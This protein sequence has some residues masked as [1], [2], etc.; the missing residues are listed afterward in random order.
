MNARRTFWGRFRPFQLS[1]IVIIVFVAGFA[2]G[3]FHNIS[4]AEGDTAPPPAA[5]DKSFEPFWQ[6][7][8][9][10]QSSYL[11]PVDQNKLVDGA[12]KGM[13]DSLGDQFSAYMDPALYPVL[14]ASLSGEIEGIG[15]TVETDEQTKAVR[16]VSTMEGSPAR[17]AG[18]QPGD[19]FTKVNGED[20]TGLSQVEL[21]VKVRGKAGT[22]VNLTMKRGDKSVDFEITRAHID[23]PNVESRMLDNGI[24]YIRLRNF[25]PDARAKI[26]EALK[27][28]DQSKLKGIVFDLRE[29]PGG[30]LTSAI[31][32]ASAFIK[33]GTILVEDFG[34]GKQQTFTST[35]NTIEPTVPMVVLVDKNSASASELVAGALQD[36][37]RATILGETTFGKGTVQTWQ[38]LVNGGGVRLTIARW[39]TPNGHW[40]H[41]NGITP[42]IQVP[43]PTENR[44]EKND[45]QL[46]AALDFFKS[47]VTTPSTSA[48]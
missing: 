6:V 22:V 44:D 33:D 45:P 43:W 48:Q 40:I 21:V 19:V 8:N 26:D 28:M 46:N 30:L 15:A 1:F 5:S 39:L 41:K 11:D 14:N 27:Q 47:S 3:N 20:V 7:Y 2:L 42:D 34:K 31:D 24:G 35:G 37:K 13:V 4:Q 17:K 36:R 18:L 12:I 10:I 32:V 29:N 38:E 23:L 16:V 9:L 25:T